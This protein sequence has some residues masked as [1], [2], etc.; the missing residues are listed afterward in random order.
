MF[1]FLT[2]H[3][4]PFLNL[5]NFQDFVFGFKKV[6]LIIEKCLYIDVHMYFPEF[7]DH[8]RDHPINTNWNN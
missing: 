5:Q 8:L 4:L 2:H 6:N 1:S 7:K 3:R